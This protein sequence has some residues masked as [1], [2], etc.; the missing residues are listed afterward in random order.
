M[1]VT[2]NLFISRRDVVKSKF[3]IIS[4]SLWTNHSIWSQRIF[5]RVYISTTHD[6]NDVYTIWQRKRHSQHCKPSAHCQSLHLSHPTFRLYLLYSLH[7]RC[8]YCVSVVARKSLPKIPTRF[9]NPL[10]ESHHV[11]TDSIT[12]MRNKMHHCGVFLLT[13]YRIWSSNASELCGKPAVMTSPFDVS[14]DE[15][16]F[17]IRHEIF[18]LLTFPVHHMYLT[19]FAPFSAGN[20]SVI[21]TSLLNILWANQ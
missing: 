1:N 4:K 17:E 11:I 10:V 14:L 18:Y 20:R 6:M 19:N 7:R 3:H 21:S 12:T 13:K 8:E 2:D 5:F 15:L 16:Y 9:W